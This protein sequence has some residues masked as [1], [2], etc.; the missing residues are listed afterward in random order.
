MTDGVYNV[1]D[2]ATVKEQFG[3]FDDDDLRKIWD[4]AKYRDKRRELLALMK[5]T[6]FELCYELPAINGERQGYLAPQLLPVDEIDY[7]WRHHENN[8]RFEY[9]YK[10]MPKGMLARF[11]VKRHADIVQADFDGEIRPVHWRYGVLLEWGNTRALVRERYFEKKITIALEGE[12]KQGFLA[13]IRRSIEEIHDDFN[14]LEVDEMVPCNCEACRATH[15]P[16]FYRHT[17]LLEYLREGVYE[18]RCEQN[19]RQLVDV[20][21]LLREAILSEPERDGSNIFYVGGDYID[22]DGIEGSENIAIGRGIDQSMGD[23]FRRLLPAR[24]GDF[25]RPVAGPGL[26]LDGLQQ[27]ELHAALLAA[28]NHNEMQRLLNFKLNRNMHEISTAK[29]L[30][31]LFDAIIQKSVRDGWTGALVEQA[32]GV[33]AGNADLATFVEKYLP[34]IVNTT[35]D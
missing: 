20:R 8:L 31:T 2:N 10:F 19:I 18:I 1:L 17:L 9:R 32:Y 28:F 34:E 25:S 27:E 22:I 15:K 35:T 14:N 23:P 16:H 7:E 13:I 5:N 33:N 4:G 21:T 29:D 12:N 24:A 6:K 11:I 30:Q 26:A 3:R